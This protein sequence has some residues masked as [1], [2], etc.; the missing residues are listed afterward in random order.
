MSLF[1]PAGAGHEG[2]TPRARW[3]RPMGPLLLLVNRFPP[4]LRIDS[5]VLNTCWHGTLLHFGLQ[6]KQITLSLE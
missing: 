5:P 3:R 2:V 6:G 1:I 4:C